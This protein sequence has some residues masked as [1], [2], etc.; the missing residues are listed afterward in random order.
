M[1]LRH[2]DGTIVHLAYC[3]NVHAAEDVNGVIGQL[4]RYA[5]PIRERLGVDRLGVGLWLA[6]N[7]VREL[8]PSAMRRLR[9]EL[10][11]RGLE[12]VTL[13]AFPYAGFQ[14]PVVKKAVYLPDW[15][16]PRR[17]DYTLAC[18]RVLAELL[19]DDAVRGSIS[20]LPLAW[21][22]FD[23]V[24]VAHRAL[25]TL[26]IGL[27][28][29][30]R[31]TGRRIRVGL[32]PEPGCVIET[33][34]QAVAELTTVDREWIGVCL[35]A[36]HLAV[37]FEDPSAAVGRL[38]DAGLP[39]VKIQASN[40]LEAD[41]PARLTRYAEPRFLHQTKTMVDGR[42]LSADD[43][44]DA[45]AGALPTTSPWRVHY[46]VP[47]HSLA[48]TTLTDTL[49]A[50]FDTPQA[51]T[52]HVEVETYTWPVLP[53]AVDLVEGIAAELAWTRDRLVAMGLKESA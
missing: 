19:P 32:E 17:L 18:A 49:S 39:I 3:T 24:A 20:T 12:V 53:D 51:R 43:L 44:P 40:A 8:T 27:A 1:R 31:A 35:D 22:T 10:A 11:I 36:C 34:E 9:A 6:V 16:D 48:G 14:Q 37:A 15:A 30:Y 29:L 21:R 7:V 50:L 13:N 46:H 25:D 41:D 28:D 23:R 4:A 47:L 42:I 5:E 2:P 26:A 45:L 33:T 38:V 52:D